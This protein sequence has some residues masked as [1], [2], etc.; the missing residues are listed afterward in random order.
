MT[1]R[2]ACHSYKELLKSVLNIARKYSTVRFA[3][4]YVAE[5]LHELRMIE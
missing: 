4:E 1:G 5:L 3:Q 2:V